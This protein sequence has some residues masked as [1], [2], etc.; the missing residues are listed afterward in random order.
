MAALSLCVF[1]YVVPDALKIALAAQ[2]TR[3]LR[4]YA[5]GKV[6]KTDL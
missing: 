2:L 5:A 1:P 6:K 4:P 3:R